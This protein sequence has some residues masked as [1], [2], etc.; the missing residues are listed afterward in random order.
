M[1]AI[2]PARVANVASHGWTKLYNEIM[3]WISG[4]YECCSCHGWLA[5]TWSDL[6]HCPYSYRLWAA[7]RWWSVEYKPKESCYTCFN[8]CCLCSGSPTLHSDSSC[9]LRVL[10]QSLWNIWMHSFQIYGVWP[11]ASK[12]VRTW[13]HFHN[14]VLLAW[15]LLRLAP[16]HCWT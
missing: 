10:D 8:F 12:H 2:S 14:A 1:P 11:Q 7:C 16:L 15:D 4:V 9:M 3:R 6:N 5:S 13:T